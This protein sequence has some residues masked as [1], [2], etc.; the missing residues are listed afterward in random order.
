MNLKR[1]LYL[2]ALSAFL[3]F[4]SCKKD[5]PTEP[6]INHP[7]VIERIIANPEEP[8]TDDEVRLECR[9]DDPDEGDTLDYDWRCDKGY[10]ENGIVNNRQVTWNSPTEV[11]N[12][13]ITVRVEDKERA[14]NSKGLELKVISRFDTLFVVEDT[15]T[16]KYFPEWIT[17]SDTIYY[18]HLI[19]YKDN[20][21]WLAEPHLRYE[22]PERSIKSAKIG[23]TINN[24]REIDDN[25]I[26]ICDIHRINESW[27]SNNLNWIN[28][29]DFN[30]TPLHRFTIP[31][32]QEYPSTFYIEGEN[33]TNLVDSW[34]SSENYGFKITTIQEG[35]IRN[36]YSKEGNYPPI[37][38]VE[39]E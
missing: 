22:T 23:F 27:S 26:L 19:I 21:E 4:S 35:V 29:P 32:V 9:A 12:S 17:Q 13:Y 16:E 1:I 8:F 37:I 15:F 36:V 30:V 11:G 25:I 3:T 14:S 31:A 24:D 18:K 10:F 20:N 7:P 34:R 5:S 33:I 39:Y 38:I 6:K 28:K 2:S